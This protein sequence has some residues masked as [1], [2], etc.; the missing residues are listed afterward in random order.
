MITK[1]KGTTN[2]IDQ[3]SWENLFARQVL[4]STT[5]IIGF[6]AFQYNDRRY[7]MRVSPTGKSVK[8]VDSMTDADHILQMN[9]W[10]RATKGA[11][12]AS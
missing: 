5:D 3:L 10:I 11:N 6:G 4:S 12:N 7:I 9:N 8:R 1:V 2:P